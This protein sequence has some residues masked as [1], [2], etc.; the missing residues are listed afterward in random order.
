MG[1]D[2]LTRRSFVRMAGLASLTGQAKW[3][4]AAARP[5]QHDAVGE[6]P[7]FAFVG[8]SGQAEGVHIYAIEG[9]RWRLQQIVSSKAPVSLALHPSRRTLYVLN[10]ISEFQ[11]LPTGSVEAYELDDKTGQ[12]TLLGRQGLS[13]SATM[14][15]HMA[16][17]P[18]AKTLAIAVH[19]GGA[20]NL[21]PILEDGHLGRVHGILKETGS[22]PVS[23]HQKTAH[24]QSIVFDPTGRRVIAADLGSDRI[25]VISVQDDFEILTRHAMPAGSGPRHLALHPNGDLL[26]VA[27]ALDGSLAAFAYNSVTGKIT[28]NRPRMQ[29]QF[30][31]ALCM[32]S[33]GDLLLTAARNEITA[34]RIEAKT[35][36]LEQLHSLETGSDE[37]REIIPYPEGQAIVALTNKSILEMK[38]DG[39][40]GRIDQPALAA[41][42]SGA[43]CFV[44]V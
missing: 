4:H 19:G 17:A 13:L 12:L 43:R 34:W 3:L 2:S 15:R 8:V 7:K 30:C 1:R 22:G 20:Y 5:S 39:V 16:V 36:A 26:Y 21:L 44:A 24:P 14:P 23:A 27:N 11:G 32:Y 41:S 9:E 25:S 38:F 37:I 18:D 10:E 33:T 42:V 35:G 28:E 31:Q 40:G 6:R 29:E